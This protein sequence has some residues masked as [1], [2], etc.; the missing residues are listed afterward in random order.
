MNIKQRLKR[1]IQ[2]NFFPFLSESYSQEGEDLLVYRYVESENSGMGFYVDVGAHHPIR[3]SNTYLLYQR[4]WRGINIE[5]TPGSKKLFDNI[6]SRDINLECAIGEREEHKTLY[7]F[8]DPALNT[9]NLKMKERV[10][11]I[12][13]YKL[14]RAEEITVFPLEVILNKYLPKNIA[15][16]LLTIDVEGNDFSVLKS[17]NWDKYKPK[18][19]LIEHHGQ[20]LRSSLSLPITLFLEEKK[21]IAVAK[22]LNTL[23]FSL[24]TDL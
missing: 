21:Y 22:T 23:L 13:H 11:K 7:M 10:E 2:H 5:P 12:D 19:I 6:R 4:G 15:I 16:D 14:V 24:K 20:S 17:N 9:T 18:F 8:N 3:F 1:K